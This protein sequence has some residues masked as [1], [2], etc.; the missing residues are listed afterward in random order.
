MLMDGT[1]GAKIYSIVCATLRMRTQSPRA[2]LP[3]LQGKTEINS[4]KLMASKHT[5]SHYRRLRSQGMGVGVLGNEG[6]PR[7]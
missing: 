3:I 5:Q 2:I 4:E 6:H 7:K 1:P